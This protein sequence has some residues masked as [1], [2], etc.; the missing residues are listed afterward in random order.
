MTP[1]HAPPQEPPS[2]ES[3]PSATPAADNVVPIETRE[4]RIARQRFEA[5]DRPQ[6]L[7]SAFSLDGMSRRE[8]G[9]R[10]DFPTNRGGW[11]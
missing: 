11:S 4:Q 8:G 3:P 2:A 7:H 6:S 10:F 5:G 1:L 9:G